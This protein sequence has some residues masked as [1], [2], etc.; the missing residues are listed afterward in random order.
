MADIIELA[1]YFNTKSDDENFRHD[2]DFNKDGS[3][4]MIDVLSIAKHFNDT[5]SNYP[6]VRK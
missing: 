2:I 6:V 4:N 3:I 1:K 5:T